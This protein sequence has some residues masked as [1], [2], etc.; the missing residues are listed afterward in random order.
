[1]PG[2]DSVPRLAMSLTSTLLNHTGSWKYLRPVYRDM[3]APCN[4]RCPVGIDI[5]GYMNLLREGRVAEAI[6]LLLQE[7]PMPAVTGRVCHHPC[8]LAC[9]RRTFDEAV[10]VHAV[11]RALGDRALHVPVERPATRRDERI[12][13]IGS[14]PAGLACAWH[15]ARSGYRVTVFD[16]AIEPGG[17]LRQGIPEYRLPRVILD[18]QIERI[19][20]MGVEFR[21]ALEVGVD[22]DWNDLRDYDA[23]FVATGAHLG[24]SLGVPGEDHASVRSGLA[25]LKDVNR[26]GHPAIGLAVVVI[27]GG[28]TAIDCARTAAR[29]GAKP[30]VLYRRTRDEMPAI[31][32]EVIDA[33]QEGITFEFLAAPS[34]FIVEHDTLRGVECV[35]MEQGEPDASGRRRPVPQQDGSFGI[36]A[37]TVLIATGE[38]S[39]AA[40]LPGMFEATDHVAV[41]YFG[42]IVAMQRGTWKG[43]PRARMLGRSSPTLF[44]AGGDVA[45]DDRTVAHALGSGKRAAIGIDRA[46]TERRHE[47][48]P[49]TDEDRASDAVRG[50]PDHRD[51]VELR[52]GKRGNVSMARFRDEDPVVRANPVND[53]VA[54]DQLNLAHFTHV[55]MHPDAHGPATVT[56]RDEVNAGISWDAAMEEAKRCFNCGVCNQCELCLIFCGD[57]AISR[58]ADGPGFDIDLDYCK[59]CGVCAAECPRGA[60]A[61]TREAP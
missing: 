18:A 33:E 23:V 10:S 53:V 49:A 30:L 56:A 29:L 21:C 36:D 4:E 44:F 8:E 3:V 60:I 12:A 20:Q 5:E 57:V 2:D 26:G 17:M 14:G 16:D 38:D 9:N 19:R 55:R 40:A 43:G 31:A 24:R 7:N 37:D 41:G 48:R 46:L 47:S 52:F 25:F 27:G 58:R 39:N 15:L 35:R 61:M 59:G 42:D 34:A 54:P 50:R 22:I 11:E 1:M 45:G 32:E 28:N 51:A 13:I 6:D